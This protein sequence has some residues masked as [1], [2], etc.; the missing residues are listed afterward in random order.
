MTLKFTARQWLVA[1][2]FMGLMFGLR[3]RA[4]MARAAIRDQPFF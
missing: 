1:L 3:R 2:P 4:E